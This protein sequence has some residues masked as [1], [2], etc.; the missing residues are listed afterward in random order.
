MPNRILREGINSSLRVDELSAEAEVFYRRLMSAV[1]DFGRFDAHPDLLLSKLYPLRIRKIKPGRIEAWL[2]ETVKAGLVLVYCA[3][4]KEYLE[5]DDFRQQIRSKI[6]KY[7]APA[8]QMLRTCAADEIICAADATQMKSFAHLDVSVSG[9]V[10]VSVSEDVSCTE[11]SETASVPVTIEDEPADR[12]VL[13]FPV[14]KTISSSA[15]QW[16]LSES[17]LAEWQDAFPY[18]NAF[19]ECRKA[20]QWVIDNP[21]RRKTAAGMTKFLNTW[22]GKSQNSKGGTPN[23]RPTAN[24]AREFNNASSFQKFRALAAAASLA[25]GGGGPASSGAIVQREENGGTD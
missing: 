23:V 8:Q 20:L 3:D 24:Q 5:I 22:M 19:D 21:T 14:N 12:I 16:H 18:L 25:E 15:E 4:G 6:S 1:D 9:D 13:T 17:K 10:S 2:E 11:P 7:P